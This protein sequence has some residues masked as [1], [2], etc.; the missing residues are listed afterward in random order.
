[1]HHEILAPAHEEPANLPL[2][3]WTN[4]R[5]RGLC[6]KLDVLRMH[7]LNS[8]GKRQRKNNDKGKKVTWSH[9]EN[10]TAQPTS[11]RSQEKASNL[12]TSLKY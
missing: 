6:A 11:L 8:S 3:N 7:G 4:Y 2:V 1:M 5:G 10:P 12:H 9:P